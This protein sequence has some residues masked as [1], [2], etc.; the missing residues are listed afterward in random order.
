MPES[1]NESGKIWRGAVILAGAGLLVK[2]LSV[3]YRIP[4]QN[5]AG[6]VGLYVYQQIYPFYALAAAIGGTGFPIVLSKF[7]AESGERNEDRQIRRH[8]LFASLLICIP[9]CLALELFALP[10]TQVMGDGRLAPLIRTLALVYLF[11]PPIAMLRGGFQGKEE[12]MLPTAVSQIGEQSVRVVLI[13]GCAW[14]LF[15]HN[16]SAYQF[17]MV[18]AAGTAAAPAVSLL[19]LLAFWKRRTAGGRFSLLGRPIDWLLI[20]RMVTGGCLFSILAAPLFVFQLADALTVVPLLRRVHVADPRAAKGIYDRIFL[21]TQFGMVAAAALTAS[22]VPGLARL[23]AGRRRHEARALATLAVRVGLAFGLA[24]FAGLA[25]LGRQVNTMLFRNG[26]GSVSF[27]IAS[28]TLL[29]LS[30]I[31][32]ASGIF[33]ASGAPWAPFA[34]L[35]AGAVVK[36]VGNAVLIPFFA[37]NG[38][39]V[40]TGLSTLFTAWLNLHGLRRRRLMNRASPLRLFKLCLAVTGMLLVVGLWKSVWLE[41]LPAMRGT[42]T[43]VALS[44]ALIGAAI[45]PAL[46]LL[47]RYFGAADLARLP[48]FRHVAAVS[49]KRGGKPRNHC[50][51]DVNYDKINKK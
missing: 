46:L 5:F 37:I 44:G 12:D 42:A 49:T 7:V 11:V 30:L 19:I 3:V 16:G 9:A 43:F 24:C 40:A 10:L 20:R 25:L 39:A 47:L 36:L 45:F 1:R 48:L 6:D 8:G 51:P 41:R 31:L 18:A 22:M 21:L 32:T 27:V 29:T 17:G 15:R 34:Y 28:I 4:F 50:D 26:D 35:L 2:I 13:I 23:S 14:Y 33:E 38:A